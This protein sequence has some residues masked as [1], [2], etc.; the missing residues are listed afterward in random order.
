METEE[1][2]SRVYFDHDTENSFNIAYISSII[3]SPFWKYV[4]VPLAK[5]NSQ[6]QYFKITQWMYT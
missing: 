3:D 5:G 6:S 4:F 1:P 2:V